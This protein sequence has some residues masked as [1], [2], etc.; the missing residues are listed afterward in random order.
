MAFL[1][2]PGTCQVPSARPWNAALSCLILG[3]KLRWTTAEKA[4]ASPVSI[5]CAESAMVLISVRIRLSPLRIKLL[6]FVRV[7][8]IDPFEEVGG[9]LLEQ[10]ADEGSKCSDALFRVVF[11]EEL[12][13]H[14]VEPHSSFFQ[15]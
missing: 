2:N 11:T 8:A 12:V 3:T 13:Q 7:M 14:P 9:I 10:L 1:A 15:Q 4:E 6:A 5:T